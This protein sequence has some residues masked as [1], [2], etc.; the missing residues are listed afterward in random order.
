MK[1][2]LL[3]LLSAGVAFG[4]PG[5]PSPF[6]GTSELWAVPG[7]VHTAKLATVVTCTN[8]DLAPVV[9]GVE[10]FGNAGNSLGSTAV[11]LSPGLTAN[12]S[13]TSLGSPTPVLS[14]PNAPAT[15]DVPDG[16]YGMLRVLSASSKAVCS[17]V[18]VDR[19][20]NPPS[21]VNGLPIIHKLKEHG[22]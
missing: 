1:S 17:A 3:L 15:V 19:V 20:N 11:N 21:N 18:L 16:T 22:E 9:V 6:P 2:V 14:L 8:V 13:T 5:D 4:H 7:V 10:V 12:F